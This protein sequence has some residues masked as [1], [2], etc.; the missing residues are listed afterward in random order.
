[1]YRRERGSIIGA[2]LAL[3]ALAAF[4]AVAAPVGAQER[5][6]RN[7]L[8]Y[9]LRGSFMEASGELLPAYTY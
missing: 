4:L 1:M 8:L 7:A 6:D 5:L 3:S 2:A 9:Y